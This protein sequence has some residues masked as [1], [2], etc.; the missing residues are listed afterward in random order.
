MSEIL[1][2]CKVHYAEKK[3]LLPLYSILFPAYFFLIIYLRPDKTF[4]D[5]YITTFA[6]V[7]PIGFIVTIMLPLIIA[8]VVSKC[9]FTEEG[10][11]EVQGYLYGLIPI[12]RSATWNK[13]LSWD[14]SVA[15]L[16]MTPQRVLQI[17]IF[18]GAGLFASTA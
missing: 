16:P 9:R 6:I 7:G 2:E 11:H 18:L 17:K 3:I 15:F 5:A 10:V 8:S 12:V 1:L 4:S 14:T 13:V